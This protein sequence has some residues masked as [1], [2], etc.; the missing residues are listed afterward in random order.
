[1]TNSIRNDGECTKSQKIHFEEAQPLHI[2]LVKLRD[3]CT[4]R[5]PHG[6]LACKRILR[7]HHACRMDGDVARQSLDPP[8]EVDHPANALVPLVNAPEIRGL[9]KCTLQRDIQFRRDELGDG[10]Y[11]AERHFKYAPDIAD[12]SLCPHRTERCNLRDMIFA[13]TL[14][15]IR[16]HPS[17]VD[18]VKVDINIRHGDAFGIEKSLKEE[19]ILEWVNVRDAKEIGYNAARC[20]PAPG[21]DFNTVLTRVVD[22]IPHD[23]K[24]ACIPHAMNDAELIV[25]TC[26]NLV[27]CIRIACKNTLLTENTQIGIVALIVVRQRVERKLQ[28]TECKIHLTACGNLCRILNRLRAVYKKSRHLLL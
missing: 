7:N 17:A 16:N 4:I 28:L 23:E 1:M 2:I 25:Q 14:L 22:K 3:Q 12:R 19:C 24:I 18:I 9:M 15:D 8:C 6:H 21:T 26:T 20:R 13:V 27:R 11:F 5:N 10:R